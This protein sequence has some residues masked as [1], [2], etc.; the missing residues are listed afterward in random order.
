MKSHL[1]LGRRPTR[2]QDEEAY[3]EVSVFE[4]REAAAQKARARNLGDYVA[5]LEVPEDAIGSRNP[6]SGHV[7]LRNTTPEQLLGCV[8]GIVRVEDV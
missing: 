8:Q 4:T 2:P 5:E 3:R 7:G 6:A 1:D